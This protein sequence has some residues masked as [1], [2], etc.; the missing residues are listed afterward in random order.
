MFH[1]LALLRTFLAALLLFWV[2]TANLS[3]AEDTRPRLLVLTDIGGDPDDQQSMTRLMLYT[4]QFRIE[5]LIA[6]ASGTPGELK[7]AVTRTD[8]IRQIVEAY[9]KVRINLMK[10]EKGWPEKSELL[11]IIKSGNPQRGR[12]NIGAKFDTEGSHHLIERID[13]GSAEDPLNIAIWGGQTDLAQALWRVKATR[14]EKGLKEFVR[15]FRVYDINDQDHIADWMHEQFPGMYYILS[16]APKGKD[17]RLGT[18][19]GMYLGGDEQLTSLSWVESNIKS[20]SPLGTQY[21]TKTWTSPNAHGCMKE[22]DTPSW[23]FF[24]PLGHNDPA[25]PTQPGWGGTYQ[26]TSDGWYHDMPTSKG[27]P[28][29]SVSRWRPEFQKDFALRMSWCVD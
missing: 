14:G 21:P 18:Y 22:G 15:K 29:V 24:L 1:L 23:F 20:K 17:K 3:A 27:D 11:S 13:A 12:T 9:G 4:N 10:H 19:R 16:E 6:S 28:R 25:D 2:A 5:G 7:Q 8:L 26:K